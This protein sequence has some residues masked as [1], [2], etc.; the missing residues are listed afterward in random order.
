MIFAQSKYYVDALSVNAKQGIQTKLKHGWRPNLA[1]VG[2]KNCKDTSTI[3]PDPKHFKMVRRVFDLKLLQD[4]SVSQ[5]HRI[6]ADRDG[7]ITPLR[8]SRGGKRP[9]RSMIYRILTNP[10][11]AGY[12]KWNGK[13]YEGKHKP[14]ITKSEFE[15]V[16]ELLGLA[17]SVR[18]KIRAHTYAGIFKCGAC[19]LSVTAEYKRK[20]SGKEYTYYHCTRV[21]RIP[22]CEQLAIE[23]K[24]LELQVQ[25]FIDAVSLSKTNWQWLKA[26]MS[27]SQVDKSESQKELQ[28]NHHKIIAKVERQISNLTDLRI[29]DRISSEKFDEKREVLQI[30]LEAA[31][32]RVAQLQN[33]HFT[34]EP[35]HILH[36]NRLKESPGVCDCVEP[37]FIV[38]SR[39][40]F[41]VLLCLLCRVFV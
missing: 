27:D 3:K 37:V 9:C 19:G 2:Y 13:L 32:E 17:A 5:I 4:K 18:P 36:G 25:A 11:Y 31:Q 1:P 7:Y 12:I 14:V 10:F 26:T 34:L 24:T 8:K 15:K 16:Q 6:I 20:P 28:V 23:E 41:F 22:N 40:F 30:G 29:E 21:H 35:A 39:C 38:P 33:S